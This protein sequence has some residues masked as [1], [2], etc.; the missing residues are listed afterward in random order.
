MAL[1]ICAAFYIR[2]SI[3][4]KDSS[5]PDTVQYTPRSAATDWTK[6]A[7]YLCYF[8]IAVGI[9]YRVVDIFSFNP[10]H[11]IWSDPQ[12]HLEQ[13]VDVLRNDPMSMTDPILFQLYMGA[14]MQLTLKIPA[15]V[16]F[17]TSIL[18]ISGPW[19][20]YRFFRELQENKLYALIGWAVLSILPGWIGIYSYFM[21]E[22]LMLPLLGLALY[23]TWRCKRKATLTSFAIMVLVWALAGLTRGICIPMAAIATLWVWSLQDHKIS[24]ALL[25]FVILVAILGPLTYRAYSSMNI[26]APHGIG[27]LNLIYAKSGK[28]EIDIRY[29][30]EGARWR[31][32][33]KSPA[34]M[35]PPLEPFS[36]WESSREGK[37]IVSIDIDKGMSD[38][39]LAFDQYPWTFAR[40]WTLTRENLLFLFFAPSWPDSNKERLSGAINHY[41]RWIWAPLSMLCLLWTMWQGW[42]YFKN[43]AERSS[44]LKTVN[45][46][47]LLPAIIFIWFVVQGFLAISVNEGRYRKPLTGLLVAQFICLMAVRD[48][49]RKKSAI[50]DEVDMEPSPFLYSRQSETQ[51]Q[52]GNA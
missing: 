18:A 22:T 20:W 28:Q 26:F 23:C 30:R 33:F 13:G 27:H 15:L 43:S 12:R 34:M 5:M 44:V 38:W 37:V 51:E 4:K 39:K 6:Y 17:Y 45:M 14:L 16:A 48:S 50:S 49:Y 52:T 9:I 46:P 32:I 47:W 29:H 40:Y 19:I 41:S 31:Y 7:Y 25:G 35:T 11:N 42:R 2:K 21:Q 24:R 36:D 10:I 1:N 8:F 3:P